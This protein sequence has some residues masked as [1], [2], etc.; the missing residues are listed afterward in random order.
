MDFSVFEFLIILATT[1]AL[2]FAQ[3]YRRGRSK[4]TRR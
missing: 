1:A 4:G 3:V 2:M